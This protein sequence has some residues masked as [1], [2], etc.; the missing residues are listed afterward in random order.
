M[1]TGGRRR[2]RLAGFYALAGLAMLPTVF[3]F[4]FTQTT[5]NALFSLFRGGT[6][7]MAGGF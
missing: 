2:L 1:V 6:S 7:A 5:V 3:V 4:V